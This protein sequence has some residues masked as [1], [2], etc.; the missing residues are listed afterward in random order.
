MNIDALERDLA[1]A[2]DEGLALYQSTARTAEAENRLFTDEEHAALKAKKDEGLAI[3]TKIARAKAD[4]GM[5]AEIERL[6]ATATA[7]APYTAQAAARRAQSWGE[8]FTASEAGAFLRAGGHRTAAA[9]R[10][11]SVELPWPTG[12]GGVPIIRA[13]TLTEDPAS[14]GAL[15]IPDYRPG[16]IAPVPPPL[17]VADLFAQ[18]TTG[19]NLIS[20]M[21]EL[22]WTNAAATVAE[23]GA[24]P[25]STLTFE[26][27]TDPVRKIA[28]WLPVSEEML[29]DEPTIRSYIDA[30]L[31][32]GVLQVE[33]DQLLN[34]NGT[35]PNISGVL[36]RTGLTASYARNAALTPEQSNADA[37]LAQTMAI[38]AA[39]YLMPDGY[40]MHPTN[41]VS[42]LTMKTTTGEYFAGGPFSPIREPSLWGLPIAVTPAIAAGTALVGAFKSGGQIFRKGGV[43]VEASNSHV[44]YFVKNLV[45]IRAEERLALAIYRPAAFGTVT[46]LAPVVASA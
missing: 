21:R 17:L 3:Q 1:R 6:T 24:K 20:Y 33:Q 12:A 44:D 27:A 25:E 22:L 16:I 42:T 32:L 19:S 40:V 43:R 10:T 36:D 45:A 8:R 31:R 39:S 41:W 35:A 23:G 30:R 9:W 5:L 15:V 2:R 34:G 46:N 14:G 38:Y 7:A 18:G 13:A 37:I 26:A 28:H 29:E 4:A 11:P